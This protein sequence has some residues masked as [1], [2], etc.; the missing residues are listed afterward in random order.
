MEWWK[1]SVREKE[2]HAHIYV[3]KQESANVHAS[4]RERGG[5]CMW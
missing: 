1:G 2:S 3:R 5:S 4:V